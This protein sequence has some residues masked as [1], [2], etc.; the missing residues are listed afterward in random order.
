MEGSISTRGSRKVQTASHRDLIAG[1]GLAAVVAV[2]AVLLAPHMPKALPLPA[3]VIALVLAISLHALA[4]NSVFQPGLAFCA[5]PLLRWAVALLG[6]RVA[7][8]DI[9][10]LGVPVAIMVM[11]SMAAT[12][13]TGIGIAKLLKQNVFFG[14]LVGSATAV[15][16]ASAALATSTVLPNYKGRDTDVAFVVVG[17]N[18]L[19]T[20]AMLAYPPLCLYLGFDEKTTGV[21]LG[22]TIHDVAQVVGAGYAI[23]DTAG[24]AAAIVKLFR[25]F[26]LLPVV[27]I[28]GFYVSRLIGQREEARVAMPTFAIVFLVLCIINSIC[29]SVP[30][31]A[32]SYHVVKSL[33]VGLSTWGLLLAISAIGLNTSMK[34]IANL[35]WRHIVNLLGTTLAIA[36]LMTVGLLYIR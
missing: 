18:L 7:I 3:M 10:S 4:R 26:L 36:T 24:N 14:M 23:S 32:E 29:S 25:V 30:A 33:T 2:I 6:M 1:I 5:K 8:G 27:L 31:I 17:V 28:L 9:I 16:G 35:G 21:M 34:A 20:L 11:A 19:A 13:L 22:G 12:I 15:C